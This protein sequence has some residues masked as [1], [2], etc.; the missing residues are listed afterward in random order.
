MR[1]MAELFFRS[2]R[3]L[4]PVM[5]RAQG[6]LNSFQLLQEKLLF[7]RLLGQF[8][9]IADHFES[10]AHLMQ[11]LGPD[12]SVRSRLGGENSDLLLCPSE[13]RIGRIAPR[14]R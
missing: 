11:T 3:E 6:I 10:N 4:F 1:A 2:A 9:K 14:W 5:P 12:L 7:F 8:S 13:R